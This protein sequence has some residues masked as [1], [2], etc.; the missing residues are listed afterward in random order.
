MKI[1]I[2]SA[3]VGENIDNSILNIQGQSEIFPNGII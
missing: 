2:I 3:K 1:I